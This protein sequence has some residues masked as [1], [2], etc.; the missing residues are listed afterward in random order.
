MTD[1]AL[2]RRWPQKWMTDPDIAPTILYLDRFLHELQ[3][4]TTTTIT[5]TVNR[6][7]YDS[8]IGQVFGELCARKDPQ[9]NLYVDPPME[10][11]KQQIDS[12]T[13][14]YQSEIRLLSKTISRETFTASDNMFVNMTHDSI[15]VLP[16]NPIEN[17]T[18]YFTK[19]STRARLRGNGR[20]INGTF[21]ERVFYKNRLSRRLQYFIDVDEWFII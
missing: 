17:S 4:N 3:S 10:Q 21:D 18:V 15:L 19:D 12:Y 9:E 7:A 14:V 11:Q 16:E 20:K 13:P 2:V 5:N 1:P 8:T 6:D